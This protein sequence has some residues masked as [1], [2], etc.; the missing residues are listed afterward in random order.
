MRGGSSTGLPA[1][2][3]MEKT[4]KQCCLM[5]LCGA[6]RPNALGV[7]EQGARQ[8]QRDRQP[9]LGHTVGRGGRLASD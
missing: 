5:M 1:A 4:M 3:V 8:D 9:W 6:G 2:M 7:Q